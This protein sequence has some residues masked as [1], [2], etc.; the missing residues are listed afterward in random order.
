MTSSGHQIGLDKGIGRFSPAS[1]QGKPGRNENFVKHRDDRS[2]TE[3]L[4]VKHSRRLCT[5]LSTLSTGCAEKNPHQPAHWRCRAFHIQV[6]R[7]DDPAAPLDRWLTG[8]TIFAIMAEIAQDR[9]A[10][11]TQDRLACAD[12][13]VC[14]PRRMALRRQPGYLS[15]PRLK[16]RCRRRKII[17][18]YLCCGISCR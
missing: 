2:F 6:G 8:P 11:L 14:L 15:D 4:H 1:I 13:P 17:H 16:N 5:G 9:S 12:G 18:E 3:L 10:W 7:K